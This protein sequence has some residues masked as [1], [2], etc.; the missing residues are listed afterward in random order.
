MSPP[1]SP[2]AGREALSPALSDI[3]PVGTMN[4]VTD[5]SETIKSDQ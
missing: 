3:S 5:K 4:P 2:K 1:A